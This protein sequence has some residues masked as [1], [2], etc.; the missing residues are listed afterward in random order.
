MTIKR[1]GVDNFDITLIRDKIPIHS[2]LASLLYNQDTGYILI[3]RF[4]EKTFLEVDAAIDSLEQL[5]MQQ[6]VLLHL[7]YLGKWKL[8]QQ[9]FS[10]M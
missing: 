5:G 7:I 3:N 2:V 4:G 1:S 10:V 8:K 9:N 6:L